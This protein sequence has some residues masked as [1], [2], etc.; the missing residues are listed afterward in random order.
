MYFLMA[1]AD[2]IQAGMFPEMVSSLLFKGTSIKETHLVLHCLKSTNALSLAHS[3]CLHVLHLCGSHL[4]HFH[5]VKL[6]NHIIHLI[7]ASIRPGM[8]SQ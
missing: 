4:S 1:L 8:E 7:K 6:S 5:H 3:Q 2:G